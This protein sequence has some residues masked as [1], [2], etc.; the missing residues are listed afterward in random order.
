MI[1]VLFMFPSVSLLICSQSDKHRISL[2]YHQIKV[3][4]VLLSYWTRRDVASEKWYKLGRAPAVSQTWNNKFERLR[5]D[6]TISV[7]NK[8]SGLVWLE[9][10]NRFETH[11]RNAD[12]FRK[13]FADLF[14]VILTFLSV[15]CY[16][17]WQRIY[18]HSKCKA[19]NANS[20][21]AEA[22]TEF[23]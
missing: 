9:D 7:D 23:N 22:E 5:N 8:I 12:R 17:W 4:E 15:A 14:V 18:L 1:H 13:S 6:S 10:E 2:N 3:G 16:L 11:S 21:I 20:S 19:V